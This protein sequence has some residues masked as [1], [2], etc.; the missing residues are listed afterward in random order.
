MYGTTEGVLDGSVNGYLES[1]DILDG[2]S[3]SVLEGSLE[4][5]S[6]LANRREDGSTT[7]AATQEQVLR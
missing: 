4:G 2:L 6:F 7:S 5:I 3:E 1:E